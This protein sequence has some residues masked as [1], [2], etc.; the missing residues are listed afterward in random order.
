MKYLK[1][2]IYE[3][4]AL[5][6][7]VL[8]VVLRLLFI[9]QQWPLTNS[10]EATIGLMA[11]HIAYQHDLPIFYY[12]QQYMGALEAYLGAI[13]FLLFGS[14]L[15]ILHATLVLLFLFFLISIYFLGRILYSRGVA[16]CSLFVLAFGSSYM[17]AKPLTALGGYAETLLFSSL[18]CLIASGLSLS[19]ASKKPFHR[20]L[21]LSGFC[22]WGLC[23][24]LGLWS[25]LL[26]A[27]FVA[28]TG[29]LL[30]LCCWTELWKSGAVICLLLGLFIGAY[31]LLWYNFHAIPGNDSI[32]I[33]LRLH[34]AGATTQPFLVSLA[35]ELKGTFAVSLPMMTG[36]PFC[37]VSELSFLG[38]SSPSSLHCKLIHTGWSTGYLLLLLLS[39]IMTLFLL[40]KN[41]RQSHSLRDLTTRLYLA[42]A[43]L[44][45][46]LV[47]TLASY[48]FS[49]APL[50]WPGIHARYIIGVLVAT[51]ALLWPLWSGVSSL[52]S[53][54]STI[55]RLPGVFSVLSLL[56]IAFLFLIGPVLT[57]RDDLPVVRYNTQQQQSLIHGLLSIGAHHIYTDYWTCNS[58]A[59]SSNEQIICAVVDGDLQPSHNRVAGYYEQVHADPSAAY[60][61]PLGYHIPALESLVAQKKN[62]FRHFIFAGYYIYQPIT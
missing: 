38:P 4:L 5:V 37:P 42:R 24:G 33:F 26:I 28:C 17:M 57:W 34:S 18:L 41:Y 29:L 31:P 35:S 6:L 12:G 15:L 7:I 48:A 23:A 14:S 49:T 10:D 56:L 55:T 20:F 22:A 9:G 62:H 52:A 30:L 13:F 46:C 45:A 21:R 54:K 59:F 32:S 58:L 27:P 19:D 60:A 8:A 43:S 25:D 16:V 50:T 53:A 39:I 36:N 1:I 3:L 11:R 61:W 51:P 2:S 44:L 40:W 47:L